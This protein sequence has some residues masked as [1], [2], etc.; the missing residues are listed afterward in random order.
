VL[1]VGNRELSRSV[2][3]DC[4]LG[5]SNKGLKAI[6]RHNALVKLSR[7]VTY[8]LDRNL[9]IPSRIRAGMQLQRPSG[10]LCTCASA[11]DMS[12]SSRVTM[13][14]IGHTPAQRISQVISS[15]HI[16][17]RSESDDSKPIAKSASGI[18]CTCASALDMSG[19]SRVTMSLI[20][21]SAWNHQIPVSAFYKRC[22]P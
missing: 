19:S 21:Q 17:A 5:P 7:Q 10:I 15:S 1:R 6:L 18:L 20:S 3:E 22:F 12:G 2:T 11:L 8:M 9:M 4:K 14:L 16:Y 13:S